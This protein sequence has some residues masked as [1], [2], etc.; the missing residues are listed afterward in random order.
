MIPQTSPSMFGLVWRGWFA[1]LLVI[2]LP[3]WLFATVA[4]LLTG[5]PRA[6]QML[7]GIVLLPLIAAG[8]GVMVGGLVVLGLKVWPRKATQ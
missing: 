6:M 4:G 8:Q 3:L 5:Q 7:A 2:M 1:G